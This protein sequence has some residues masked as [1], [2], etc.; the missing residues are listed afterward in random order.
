[1]SPGTGTCTA[2]S[3]AFTV[4]STL[5]ATGAAGSIVLNGTVSM[6]T[7]AENAC[8]GRTFTIPLTVNGKQ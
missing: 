2:A 3:V 1:V 8:Q 7:G 5:P 4:T 6:P